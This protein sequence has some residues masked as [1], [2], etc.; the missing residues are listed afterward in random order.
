MAFN[1]PNG[2]NTNFSRACKVLLAP[3]EERSR[4]TELCDLKHGLT[5]IIRF[6]GLDKQQG[7]ASQE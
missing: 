3:A 6:I 2:C 5:R 7:R 4:C 1:T